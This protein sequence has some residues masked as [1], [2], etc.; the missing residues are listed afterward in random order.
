MSEMTEAEAG[1]WD[2]YYTKNT[3]MP[4]LS[5]PVFFPANMACGYNLTPKRP[6]FLPSRASCV[7]VNK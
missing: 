6:V 7:I 3:V 2:D 4:D 1:Y 5:K